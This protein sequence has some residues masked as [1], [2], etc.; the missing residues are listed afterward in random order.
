MG[1]GTRKSKFLISGFLTF[2]ILRLK[3][4]LSQKRSLGIRPK[5][6]NKVNQWIPT[7][8]R[9]TPGKKWRPKKRRMKVMLKVL[10]RSSFWY[11]E[12]IPNEELLK[13]EKWVKEG[14]SG[15]I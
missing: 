2:D 13:L 3:R 1:R 7:P 15:E 5:T 10:F 12:N 8:K 9:P 14:L 6:K 4:S 11:T